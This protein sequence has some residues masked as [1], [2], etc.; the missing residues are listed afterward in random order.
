MPDLTMVV[1]VWDGV[2]RKMINTQILDTK[3][4]SIRI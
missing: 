3:V 1:S 4:H 2:I